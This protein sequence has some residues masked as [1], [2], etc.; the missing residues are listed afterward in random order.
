MGAGPL[1]FT[2]A[3]SPFMELRN[4]WS[5]PMFSFLGLLLLAVWPRATAPRPGFRAVSVALLASV[6]MGAQF[7]WEQHLNY[8]DSDAPG[9]YSFPATRIAARFGKIWRHQTHAP[10]LIV[11]GDPL[12]AS[13]AGLNSHWWPSMFSDLDPQESPAMTPERIA[14]EGMLLV[15]RVDGGWAPPP[16]WTKG[17]V[18]GEQRF[19]WS[20]SPKAK[21]V[22]IDYAIIPPGAT[23]V[24]HFAPAAAN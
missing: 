8:T 14:R 23:D 5:V 9:Q 12:T 22:L 17:R 18:T 13:L 24:P 6:A 1:L 19:I 10:L 21:P 2:F 11:G 15:W 20:K 4:A 3:L 16:E 7:A